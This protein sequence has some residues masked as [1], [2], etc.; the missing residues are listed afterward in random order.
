[1]AMASEDV[2][3]MNAGDKDISY[4]NNSSLQKNML[5]KTRALLEDTIKDMLSKI[6]P[7][8]CIKVA[9][10][11]C[12]SGP[13]TFF[14]TYEIMDTIARVCHKEHWE[15]PELQ[16]FLNDLPQ[17]D[18]NA[19]FRSVPALNERLKKDKGELRGACFIVGVPGSFYQ[20]LFPSRSMHFV[21]SSSSLHWLS[22]APRGDKGHIYMSKSTSADAFEA[23]SAQFRMDFSKFLRLRSEE[24]IDGGRM[25]HCLVGRNS[26]DPT[27]NDCCSIYD[28][29]NKSLLDLVAK[30]L[31]QESDVD[32]FNVPYYTPSEQE[33]REIIEEEGSFNLDK[34][35]V[36]EVNWDFE[37]DDGN[38]NYVFEKNKCGRNVAKTV[39][40]AYESMLATHF[41]EA[42]VDELFTR[43]AQ[44][45]SEHLSREKTKFI[46]FVVLMSMK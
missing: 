24:M 41:G 33:V 45:V 21:Y 9:D 31:V 14:S 42:I 30:G 13:N 4:A 11:G 16:V 3:C 12:A 20:R 36:F 39:R 44:H 18:F 43:Y 7:V 19:V 46:N 40:A 28:L 38:K 1:M 34:I 25:L 35:E 17:N 27:S 15:P 6:L 37:D 26:T 29:L 22:K 8:T 23:Y 32:S 5:L 10:L 2:H